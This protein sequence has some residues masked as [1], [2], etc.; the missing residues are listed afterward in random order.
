MS[1][2]HDN[3]QVL[4]EGGAKAVKKRI[5]IDDRIITNRGTDTSIDVAFNLLEMLNGK[6]EA[7]LIKKALMYA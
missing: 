5:V 3:L 1:K 7:A 6:K 4:R 2:R